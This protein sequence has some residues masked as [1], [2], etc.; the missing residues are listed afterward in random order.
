MGSLMIVWCVAFL[1]SCIAKIPDGYILQVT[2]SCGTATN[3]DATI[4]IITDLNAEAKAVCAGGAEVDFASTDGVNFAIT[5]AY[6]S[7]GSPSSE[8]CV[9]ERRANSEVFAV[10]VVVSYGEVGSLVHQE[11]EEYT[12]SCTFD[13]VGV[14]D[15]SNQQMVE[16][17]IAPTEIQANKGDDSTSTFNLELV[18]VKGRSLSSTNVQLGRTVMLSATTSGS[19]GIRPVSCYAIDGN[20]R[21]AILRAGC[22]DGIVFPKDAGFVTTG[23]NTTSPY[24]TAFSINAAAVV[25]FTCTFITCELNTCDGSSCDNQAGP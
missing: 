10:K 17:L 22:G 8:S 3:E 6:P 24:F 5:V 13:P 18:D 19:E 2:P 12:V 14:D 20:S 15:S 23:T 11:E 16:G 7:Q 1:A 21:Y 9:F 25:S 4:N